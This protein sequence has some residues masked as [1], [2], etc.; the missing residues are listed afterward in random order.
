MV[1][2]RIKPFHWSRSNKTSNT[3]RAS[4][5]LT[6]LGMLLAKKFTGEAMMDAKK[7]LREVAG[8]EGIDGEVG[9]EASGYGGAHD[10][11]QG[12]DPGTVARAWRTRARRGSACAACKSSGAGVSVKEA[13]WL[14]KTR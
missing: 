6:T 8:A 10:E 13:R 9:G 11:R 12:H 2:K 3:C 5:V 7:R 1:K 14:E 4:G